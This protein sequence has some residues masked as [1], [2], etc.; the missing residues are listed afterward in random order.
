MKN[1]NNIIKIIYSAL[2]IGI[3][4]LPLVGMIFHPTDMPIGNQPLKELPELTDEEGKL[5]RNILMDIT[6]WYDDRFAFRPEIV[7]ANSALQ[8]KIFRQSSSDEIIVGKDGWLY[9]SATLDDF[10]HRNAVSDRMLFNIAHNIAL[11]QEYAEEHGVSFAFTIA[12]NKNSLYPWYMPD[13]YRHT[14]GDM[15]DA[16]RLKPYLRSEG[17]NYIDLYEVFNET[18][19]VF[20]YKRDSHWTE[21]GTILAYRSLLSTV[22]AKPVSL[23]DEPYA[24]E[25]LSGDLNKMLYPVGGMYEDRAVFIPDTSWSYIGEAD[26]VEENYIETLNPKGEGSLLMY[27]DSFGNSLLPY[28]AETF[29]KA[30]FS[31]AV[32]YELDDIEDADADFFIIEKVERHLPTLGNIA[33]IMAAPGR[34]DLIKDEIEEVDIEGCNPQVSRTN[35]GEYTGIS[36]DTPGLSDTRGRIYVSITDDTGERFYEAFCISAAG[37]DYGYQAYIPQED[38]IGE[39]G[40]IKIWT[41]RDAY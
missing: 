39:I 2:M 15:S 5:N 36:G 41:D 25:S 6:E 21:G 22:G 24:Y 31:K 8:E 40:N 7:T 4:L 32:P 10:Q 37:D 13:R 35:D 27:R 18:D 23:P 26:N 16:G 20:Y 33:P 3:C 29:G 28:M 30:V 1:Q 34:D 9:Y 38:I 11:M 14:V 12:P 17:V 19:G